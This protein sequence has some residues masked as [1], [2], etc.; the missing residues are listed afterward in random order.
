MLNFRNN[1]PATQTEPENSDLSGETQHWLSEQQCGQRRG[2]L[3]CATRRYFENSR[4]FLGYG[5][6]AASQLA[7]HLL[8]SV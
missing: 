8:T 4:Q 5:V 6:S 3:T 7:A 2:F 1:N